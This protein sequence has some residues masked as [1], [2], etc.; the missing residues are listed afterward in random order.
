[1]KNNFKIMQIKV[2]KKEKKRKMEK[3]SEITNVK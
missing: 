2:K 3:K 1:M